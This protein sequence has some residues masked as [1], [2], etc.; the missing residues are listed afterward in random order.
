VISSMMGCSVSQM[1]SRASQNPQTTQ[2]SQA[3]TPFPVLTLEDNPRDPLGFCLSKE[4][5]AELA[6]YIRALQ[7][8]GGSN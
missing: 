5:A 8:Q 2:V 6:L 4:D 3:N 7:R 1:S